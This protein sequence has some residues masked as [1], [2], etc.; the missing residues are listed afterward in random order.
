MDTCAIVYSHATRTTCCSRELTSR[1][2]CLWCCFFVTAPELWSRRAAP[3]LYTLVQRFQSV[4]SAKLWCW[5]LRTSEAWTEV[6]RD[7]VHEE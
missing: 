7:D 2:Y 5:T 1:E 4:W 6:P 3:R